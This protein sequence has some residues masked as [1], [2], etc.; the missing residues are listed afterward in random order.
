ME[1]IKNEKTSMILLKNVGISLIITVILLLIFSAI[2]TYSSFNEQY[3]NIITIG[4]T[5]ISILVGSLIATSKIKKKG[6]LNGSIVGGAYILIIYLI[7]SLLNWNF[8][9]DVKSLIFI[10]VGILGGLLGGIIGVNKK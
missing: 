9:F 4:I 6:I 3:I 7:S 1:N 10:G 8:N 2:L 5:A